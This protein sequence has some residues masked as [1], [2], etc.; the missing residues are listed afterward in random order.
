MVVGQRQ[1]FHC[2]GETS[3]VPSV[4]QL[5]ATSLG[6]STGTAALLDTLKNSQAPCLLLQ[7]WWP[8]SVLNLHTHCLHPRPPTL[9][10]S[11]CSHRL[12]PPPS[13]SSRRCYIC[14]VQRLG[15]EAGRQQPLAAQPWEF[16]MPWPAVSS[17]CQ[18]GRGEL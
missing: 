18:G 13:A 12:Q 10:C 8:Q 16:W 15:S 3:T 4:S 7:K 11:P 6:L 5:G 2:S 17:R 9:L 1:Q 14:W